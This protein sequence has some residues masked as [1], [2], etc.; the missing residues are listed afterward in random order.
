MDRSRYGGFWIRVGAALI[1]SVLM[2]LLL[3]PLLSLF[4]G[5]EYLITPPVQFSLGDL[6]LNYLLPAVVVILFWI[7]RSATP[8]KMLLKLKIVDAKTGGQPRTGQ[9]IV[10]YLGYYVSTLPL[11]LGLFWVG[12]DARKQGWHDK[13]AG[14]LVVRSQ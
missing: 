5:T 12:W 2:V 6:L 3:A 1:D 10:R 13:L 4:F 8:G 9:L 11:M 7:Y 14:T